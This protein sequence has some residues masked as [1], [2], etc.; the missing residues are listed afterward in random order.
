MSISDSI[1]EAV[2][3]GGSKEVPELHILP[4]V[5]LLRVST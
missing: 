4:G 5:G 1:I 2:V 3:D